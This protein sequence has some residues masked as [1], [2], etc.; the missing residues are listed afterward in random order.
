MKNTKTTKNS[1]N[2]RQHACPHGLKTQGIENSSDE[3]ANF[4]LQISFQMEHKNI[5]NHVNPACHTDSMTVFL[6]F[7]NYKAINHV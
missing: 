7:P 4:I 3:T 1:K 5:P 6:V 2:R